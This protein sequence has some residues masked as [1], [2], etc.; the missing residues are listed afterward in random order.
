[1]T[2]GPADSALTAD[3][4]ERR[5]VALLPEVCERGDEIASL[6][7]LPRDL[8][9]TLKQ[10]GA[11]RMPMP[12]AWGGPEMSLRRQIELI[13]AV[14]CADPSVGWCVMIGSDAGFYSASSTTTPAA[15][16]GP[17]STT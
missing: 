9:D 11:F 15:I 13:E 17:T 6:R 7:R 16:C 5:V 3:D 8:V 12:V 4:I 2:T 10:A 1:M 14:A